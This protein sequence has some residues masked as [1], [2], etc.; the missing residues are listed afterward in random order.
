MRVAAVIAEY[1]PFHNGHRFHIDAIRRD[2]G[3]DTAVVA[4]M[5]GSFTQR[6]EVAVA[7][8]LT[9]AAC[10][11]EGG[12]NL[13]LELPF[14]YSLSSAEFFAKA[15]VHIAHALGVV[16]TLSFGS[17]CG[18]L[19][20]LSCTAKNTSCESYRKAVA[21]ILKDSPEMG[22]AKASAEAYRMLYG[23]DSTFVY[24]PN[25]ILAAEYLRA[26]SLYSGIQPHTVRREGSSYHETALHPNAYPSAT[27]L[28]L[29]I[30]EAVLTEDTMPHGAYTLL[31]E[32][33]TDGRAPCDGER[34]FPAVLSSFMLNT[35]FA[36]DTIHDAKGGLY[37]RLRRFA[38]EATSLSSWI[39]L[40]ETKKYTRARLRR[41]LWY[42]FFGVTSS[43][44]SVP[45]AY[46]Q[47]L[48]ADDVGLTLLK[49]IRKTTAIPIL[50]KPSDTDALT[51]EAQ[52]QKRLADTAD[53]LFLQTA[54][55]PQSPAAALRGKPYLKK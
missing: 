54:P 31:R 19:A 53:K 4:I 14:P 46:T 17:E 41:A 10:A 13:V 50:T 42:S 29:A 3:E 26:L 27:A 36:P 47:L 52:H 9:R 12:V 38:D 48:G 51:V 6:G 34:L 24:S 15:G 44:V 33:I 43:D 16:D 21:A 25:D 2:L 22:H 35:P 55:I 5:S 32:A 40:S 39:A 28:R 18:D 30:K 37:H 45:P 20:R 49:R 11:I 8:K 23:E 1:N 7:D